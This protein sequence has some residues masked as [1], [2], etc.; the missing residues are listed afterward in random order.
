MSLVPPICRRSNACYSHR[1]LFL[2]F[3]SERVD[4]GYREDRE[5]RRHDEGHHRD[6]E[7]RDR[8][9]DGHRDRDRERYRRDDRRGTPRD[10]GGRPREFDEFRRPHDEDRRRDNRRE[11]DHSHRRG[12]AEDSGSPQRRGNRAR[13]RDGLGTP[14]RRSPTPEGAVPLSQQKRKASGWDVHAPGY[15]QY[16]AMQAKQ[17]GKSS[18]ICAIEGIFYRLVL[19]G[20]SICQVQIVLRFHQSLVLLVFHLPSL[21]RLSAWESAA[22]LICRGNLVDYT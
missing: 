3:Y 9:R 13:G 5:R 18:Y 4:R 21:S 16:S 7:Y 12:R 22:T 1:L 14:E 8:E 6:R 19:Q 10:H 15:E 20:F 2:L 17:T 11:D